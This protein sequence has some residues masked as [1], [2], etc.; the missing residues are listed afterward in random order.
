MQEIFLI[1]DTFL[2]MG[3]KYEWHMDP[4]LAAAVIVIVMVN[5]FNS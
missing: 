5:N 1:F 3:E 2:R 4:L